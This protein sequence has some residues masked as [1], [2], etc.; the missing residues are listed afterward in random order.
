MWERKKTGRTV[1]KIGILAVILMPL[2][3]F[4]LVYVSLLIAN[5][6]ELSDEAACRIIKNH[7]GLAFSEQSAS[8]LY[9]DYSTNIREEAFTIVADLDGLDVEE[10][11]RKLALAPGETASLLSERELEEYAVV[12]ETYFG[13]APV[14]YRYGI[15]QG[16]DGKPHVAS[17][18]LIAVSREGR[19]LIASDP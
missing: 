17:V 12:L 4:A 11:V 13:T 14:F 2:V 6:T 5:E 15:D 16:I 7:T 1:L 8:I 10:A 9:K 19:L 3:L 18:Y